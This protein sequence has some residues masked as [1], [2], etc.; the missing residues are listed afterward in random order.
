MNPVK[1]PYPGCIV[2]FHEEGGP[3]AAT[4][5]SWPDEKGCCDLFVLGKRGVT[6]HHVKVPQTPE[7]LA[8]VTQRR[9]NKAAFEM[10]SFISE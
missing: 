3:Y 2:W 10:W 6:N 8:A 1:S 9:S 7:S 4:V 5:T